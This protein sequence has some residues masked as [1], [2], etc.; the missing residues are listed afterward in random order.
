MC[1]DAICIL[2]NNPFWFSTPFYGIS[3]VAGY[4]QVG[5]NAWTNCIPVISY[6]SWTLSGSLCRPICG[7]SWVYAGLHILH[8]LIALIQTPYT[9]EERAIMAHESYLLNARASQWWTVRERRVMFTCCNVPRT[10]NLIR[11][12]G[13]NIQWYIDPS[14]WEGTKNGCEENFDGYVDSGVVRPGKRSE[15][16]ETVLHRRSGTR[17]YVFYEIYKRVTPTAFHK[18]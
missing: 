1:N 4:T 17:G 7:T 13:E 14:L 8:N 18:T 12:C 5:V 10:A 2:F 15:R 6:R 11:K 16:A 3:T 9:Q